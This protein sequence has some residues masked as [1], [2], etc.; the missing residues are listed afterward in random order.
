MTRRP[1]RPNNLRWIG[2]VALAGLAIGAALLFGPV[3]LQKR[4]AEHRAAQTDAMAKQA[5]AEYSK[6]LPKPYA[7]GLTLEAVALEGP[8]LVSYIRSAKRSAAADRANPQTLELVRQTEQTELL[9]HCNNPDV[10]R[11]LSQGLVL[12]RRFID[13]RNDIF[14]EVS[15]R[16]QDCLARR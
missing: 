15:L 12:T 4:D 1:S 2:A 6:G 9:T 3:W 13:A 16:G 8:A 14:F 10:L 11:M 5:L 7:P